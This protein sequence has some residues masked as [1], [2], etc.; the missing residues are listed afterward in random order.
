MFIKN[1][2]TLLTLLMLAPG[3]IA[4]LGLFA[5]PMLITTLTSLRQGA[6]PVDVTVGVTA[7][8]W[9]PACDFLANDGFT[10]VHFCDFLFSNEGLYTIGLSLT[11]S[12][13]AT[14]LAVLLSLPLVMILRERFRGNRFFRLLILAPMM[15]PGLIGALGLFLF[16]DKRSGWFNL[17]LTQ[18][19][20]FV[21]DPI[22]FNFTLHGLILFYT[23]LFFPYTGLTTL[24]AVEAIDRSL[25]EA[26]AVSGATRWQVFRHILFPLILPGIIAGSVLTF[27]L[28]FG[29]LSIPLMLGGNYR[30]H[31]IGSRIYT[32]ATVFRKWEAASAMA[33]VMAAIQIILI[34]VYMRVTRRKEVAR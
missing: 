8:E 32:F 26:G 34:T 31:I 13:A 19:V 16:W 17:F 15:I 10:L 7:R 3:F 27:I 11:I 12:I 23:W 24:S 5:Y 6:R 20:P 28:A 33:V 14:L 21:D 2:R 4:F 9:N 1:K 22:K 18:V 30:A 29:A 25:E